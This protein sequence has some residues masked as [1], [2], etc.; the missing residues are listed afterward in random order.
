MATLMDYQ[1]MSRMECAQSAPEA[2][3]RRRRRPARRV[4]TPRQVRFIEALKTTPYPQRAA[5]AA[6]YSDPRQSAWEL[7]H[8]SPAVGLEIQRLGLDAGNALTEREERFCQ[9]YA[10]AKAKS[11]RVSV[12]ATA[13]AAGYSGR[14]ADVLDRLMKTPRIRNRVN[15]LIANAFRPTKEKS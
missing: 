12:R 10:H 2:T 6:G 13:V 14:S 3:V 15:D 7:M 1:G 9:L 8:K 11:A 5:R 4:L